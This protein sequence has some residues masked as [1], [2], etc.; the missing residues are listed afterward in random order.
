MTNYESLDAMPYSR[1]PETEFQKYIRSTKYGKMFF[2]F[3]TCANTDISYRN[4]LK[5]ASSLVTLCALVSIASVN[6]I[7]FVVGSCGNKQSLML[8]CFVRLFYIQ[9]CKYPD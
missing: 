4:I 9:L 1:P 5:Y 8:H 6:D 3:R 7:L 2:C